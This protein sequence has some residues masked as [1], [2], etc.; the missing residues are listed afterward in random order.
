MKLSVKQNAAGRWVGVLAV[1]SALLLAVGAGTGCANKR[2]IES[3]ASVANVGPAPSSP[4]YPS[5]YPSDPAPDPTGFEPVVTTTPADPAAAE[6]EPAPAPVRRYTVKR[7]D[8]LYGIARSQYGDGK[9]W[10]R[11]AA[12]NPGLTA[13]GLKAGQTIVVP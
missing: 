4:A 1:G 10:E 9:Q 8:T 2:K 11:I 13:A 12:A 7:G 3:D 5:G 6:P